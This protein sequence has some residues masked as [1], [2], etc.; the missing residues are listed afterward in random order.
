MKKSVLIYLM[1]LAEGI[2]CLGFLAGP[3]H[4]QDVGKM[5]E[6]QRV[7][8]TTQQKQLE[9][10]QKQLEAQQKQL[11]IQ[12]KQDD[13]QRQ[14]LQELQKQIQSLAKDTDTSTDKDADMSKDKAAVKLPTEM[15]TE[16][17][18][19]PPSKRAAISQF[20]KHDRTGAA[21]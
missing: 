12:Q 4:A 15:T 10:Q 5:Q 20:G 7:I 13:A 2:I 1:I 19:V 17:E 6:L 21:G 11:E 14:L 18:W 3:A 16:P 9:A 8:D